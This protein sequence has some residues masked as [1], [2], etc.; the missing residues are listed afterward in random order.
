MS[1]F[2][3]ELRRKY[4]TTRESREDELEE[5]M[6]RDRIETRLR[7]LERKRYINI[8]EDIKIV[9]QIVKD[10]ERL[11]YLAEEYDSKDYEFQKERLKILTNKQLEIKRRMQEE[12]SW[13]EF[14]EEELKGEH[15]EEGE[16]R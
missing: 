16:E 15:E 6:L 1:R 2:S 5:R 12:P 10:Y 9:E 14:M 11:R 13:T 8:E 4:D 3:D 7:E